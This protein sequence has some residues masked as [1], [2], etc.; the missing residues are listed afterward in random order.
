MIID[1]II[2]RKESEEYSDYSSHDFY[3]SVTEY[4]EGTNFEISRAMDSGEEKDVKQALCNYIM[5]NG[6]SVDLCDYINSV[7]W[8]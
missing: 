2:D 6:Y 3:N 1:L 7:D 4:E 8:L 5:D